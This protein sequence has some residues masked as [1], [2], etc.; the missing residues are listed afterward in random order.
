[1]LEYNAVRLDRHHVAGL[2]QQVAGFNSRN[3]GEGRL[4]HADIVAFPEA[5]CRQSKQ[6][7]PPRPGTSISDEIIHSRLLTHH[8][9]KHMTHS[10]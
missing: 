10:Q 3:F 6:V 5:T 7:K 2:D 1:V 8:W 9:L 4:S